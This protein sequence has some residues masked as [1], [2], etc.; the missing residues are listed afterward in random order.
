M[1]LLGLDCVSGSL[2]LRHAAL[3]EPQRRAPV[4]SGAY[5]LML[6]S[7]RQPV[8]L[9]PQLGMGIDEVGDRMPCC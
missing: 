5:A 9:G 3:E 6:V 7:E 4:H 8:Q 2:L 1:L